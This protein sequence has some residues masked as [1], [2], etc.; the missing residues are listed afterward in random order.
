V[1]NKI[2]K[3]VKSVKKAWKKEKPHLEQ[4]ETELKEAVEVSVK[5]GVSLLNNL[6]K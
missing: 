2:K 1:A 3:T 5:K 6:I 4:Y